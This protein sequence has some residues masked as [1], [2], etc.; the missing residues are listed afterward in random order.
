M[1]RRPTVPAVSALRA[2][3]EQRSERLT[4][5]RHVQ[6][7]LVS[8]AGLIN[9]PVVNEA[10][11]EIGRVVDVVARW[12]GNQP[13]PPVTGLIV[14][15]GRRSAWLPI[16]VVEEFR[17][18]LIRLRTSRLDLRDFTRRHGEVELA[19]DVVDH[20]LVDTDG[21]RVVRASDL[22]LARVA[23]VVQLVG[24]DV[25][26]GS[27][28]RRLG[29]A[30][31]RV[32]PTPEKVIDWASITSFGSER[33]AGG[34]L[35][36]S[37]RGLQRMRPGELADLLEDLGRSERKE[38]LA[39][40]SP[41]QAADALEEMQPDELAQL[42]RES[43]T[44]DAA[45]LLGRMEPDEAADG[46]RELDADEQEELM[47]AMPA[48]ASERVAT[49]LGYGERTAGGVMT[50]LLMATTPNETIAQV[51]ERLRANRDH[52]EDLAGV[53]VVDGDGRLLD[54]LT[55]TELFLADP[56]SSVN[57]LI[58]PP[59]PVTVTLDA[60]PEQIAERLVESRS[61]S[62]LVVDDDDRPVGRIMADDLLDAL[63]PDR[64]RFRFPRRLS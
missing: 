17:R 36:A 31:F 3:Y 58:G 38:L 62:L 40:L 9:R 61:P 30:R 16:E 24:V 4:T 42:L 48:E 12:D 10:G 33:G 56:M 49:L 57:E 64:V 18:D 50:T 20:Q 39:H 45:A 7:A 46:L 2:R 8:L 59:W 37:E 26:F 23:G 54:D 51:R 44:V 35:Q 14:R 63:V 5:L 43:E 1:A 28:L 47:A 25:G 53:V 55:M 21:A 32:L 15:V 19:R 29:P 13:Y 22:Y 11:G 60:D 27:I 6:R 52:D 34:R 41:D